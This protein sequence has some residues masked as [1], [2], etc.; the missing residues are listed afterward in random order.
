MDMKEQDGINLIDKI[1]ADNNL[2]SAYEKVRKNKG[3]AGVDGMT[4]FEL[5]LHL[6]E[7][8][9]LLKESLKN[10]SYQP[11]PVKRVAIPKPDGTKRNLGIPTVVDRTVQQAILQIIEPR[12]DP[13]FSSKSFGYRKGRSAHQAIV[14]AQVY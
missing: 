4:V 8:L 2:W 6:E 14:Q 12:I 1:I 7:N 13:H 9:S 3:A 10:N 11:Q 5:K